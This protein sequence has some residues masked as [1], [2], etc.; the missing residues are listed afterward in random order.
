VAVNAE[1]AESA[2]G[3]LAMVR[4]L[5]EQCPI[6]T[7]DRWLEEQRER[8]GRD[9]FCVVIPWFVASATKPR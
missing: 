5:S 6:E 3:L 9:R 2:A 4:R 8:A 7:I 1:I